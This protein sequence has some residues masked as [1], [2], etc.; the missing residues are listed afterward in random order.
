MFC[1]WTFVKPTK[2]SHQACSILLFQLI[3]TLILFYVLAVNSVNPTYKLI[4][5]NTAVRGL[6]DTYTYTQILRAHPR[7]SVDIY[8]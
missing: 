1:D 2:L 3:T 4:G 5:C 6:T 8:Q 7:E